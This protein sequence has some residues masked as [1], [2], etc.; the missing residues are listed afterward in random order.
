MITLE[1]A[2][3]RWLSVSSLLVLLTAASAAADPADSSWAERLEPPTA[4]AVGEVVEA[5]RLDGLPVDPLIARALEGASRGA[6]GPRIVAAVR[7]LAGDMKHSRTLL[8][9]SSTPSELIASSVALSAGVPAETLAR[10]RPARKE[11]TLVT[12]LVVLADLVTRRVPVETAC[13]AVLA[14]V[15]A[16]VNDEDL[17]RL[18]E[19]IDH[20]IRAGAT[21]DG[22]TVA[23]IRRLI[24]AFDRPAATQ[25]G[26]GP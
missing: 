3:G 23:G 24:G 5:A 9:S 20:D 18:R 25:R 8:G 13:A 12:P 16:G 10:L 1:H 21:P 4:A 22:A 19:R 17:M 26:A 11:G 14:A 7:K 6:A 15:R 2:A